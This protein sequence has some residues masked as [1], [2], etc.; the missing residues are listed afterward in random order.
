M[1]FGEQ[2][3]RRQKNYNVPHVDLLK[4]RGTIIN[5][6]QVIDEDL[7]KRNTNITL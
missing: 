4:I 2:A 6:N 5:G 1:F 3:T 7:K